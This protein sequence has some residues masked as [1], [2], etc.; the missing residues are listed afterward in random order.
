MQKGNNHNPKGETT[1]ITRTTGSTRKDIP[2]VTGLSLG[3]T[4][5]DEMQEQL[6][7]CYRQLHSI[8]THP[9]YQQF[10]REIQRVSGDIEILRMKIRKVEAHHG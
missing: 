9:A 10:Q 6:I 2:S 1:P 5:T 3:P 7:T 8:V 4:Q